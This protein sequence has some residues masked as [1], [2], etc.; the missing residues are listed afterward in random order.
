M[1]EFFELLKR[2][3]LGIEIK[4]DEYELASDFN[5]TL[6]FPRHKVFNYLSRSTRNIIMEEV[7]RSTQRD[8]IIGLLNTK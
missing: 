7:D 8:K 4:M 1:N 2:N 5:Q 6:F 3:L